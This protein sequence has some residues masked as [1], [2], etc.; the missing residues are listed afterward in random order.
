MQVHLSGY[1]LL[2][3]IKSSLKLKPAV[4]DPNGLLIEKEKRQTASP[5]LSSGGGGGVTSET[6][7][8]HLRLNKK[9]IMVNC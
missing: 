8:V 1:V 6:Q 2:Y 3:L 9:Q 5:A 7:S 4:F